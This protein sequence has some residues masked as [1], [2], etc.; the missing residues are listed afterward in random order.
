M[1][2]G[3]IWSVASGESAF[4]GKPRPALIVQNDA[5]S[6]VPSVVICP[7][8]SQLVEASAA[9]ILLRP[10]LENGLRADSQ[11]MVDK[12]VTVTRDKLRTRIGA[13]DIDT[14]R[15]VDKALLVFLDLSVF[16]FPNR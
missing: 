1:R 16:A 14:L 9:R 12:I 2:R 13:L 11:V 10:S 6:A 15:E 8:T 7:L 5:F 3:E 4:T